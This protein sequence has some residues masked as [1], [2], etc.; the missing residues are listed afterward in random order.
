MAH[1]AIGGL[2]KIGAVDPSEEHGSCL[3]RNGTS[4]ACP[5]CILA[6]EKWGTR[7]EPACQPCRRQRFYTYGLK[8]KG[9]RTLKLL[10]CHGP[11]A[12]KKG[13]RKAPSAEPSASWAGVTS[14]SG[15]EAS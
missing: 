14:I 8:A 3:P 7:T 12:L 4:E 11:N 15:M 10:G 13:V 1:G 2:S 6:V 9:W 5:T